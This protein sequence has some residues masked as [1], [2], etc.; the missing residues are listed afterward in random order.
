MRRLIRDVFKCA[1]WSNPVLQ[2][3]VPGE[4]GRA[5]AVV[6]PARGSGGGRDGAIARR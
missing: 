6:R 3:L 5:E 2:G 1:A 4:P